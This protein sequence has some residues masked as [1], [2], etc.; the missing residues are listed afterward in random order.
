MLT[1]LSSWSRSRKAVAERSQEISQFLAWPGDNWIA[2]VKSSGRLGCLRGQLP[3]D[4]TLRPKDAATIAILFKKHA[5]ATASSEEGE[6]VRFELEELALRLDAYASS[7]TIGR[8]T[9]RSGSCNRIVG[10]LHAVFAARS[11]RN[12][13]DAPKVME[14][15]VRAVLAAQPS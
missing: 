13:K 6:A 11:L 14:E 7:H 5:R 9:S 8:L 3:R 1:T 15:S 12:R 2:T 10:L 4:V